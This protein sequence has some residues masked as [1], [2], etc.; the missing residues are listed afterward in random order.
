MTEIT[1][2]RAHLRALVVAALMQ[3]VP[4]VAQRVYPSRVF[5]QPS[6]GR[7]PGGASQAPSWP[8]LLV[9]APRLRR[10]S[11]ARG[12]AAPQY[13]STLTINVIARVERKTE[14]EAEA[15]LDALATAIDAAILENP[16]VLSA[17]EE[18]DEVESLRELRLDGDRLVGQDAIA[19]ELRFTEEFQP[20]LPHR[21]AEARLTGDAIAPFDPAATNPAIAG[22]PAPA[23]PPR[24]SGPDGQPETE[25]RI[26]YPI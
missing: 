6:A 17:I 15:E 23:A 22:F 10:S 16:D 13:R 8:A 25:I 18:I 3:G 20:A 24:T 5:P 14:A 1:D 7:P 12:A 4:A 26:T 9:Y 19:F 11:V 21:L 2:P